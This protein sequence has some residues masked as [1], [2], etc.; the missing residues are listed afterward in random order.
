MTKIM[1]GPNTESKQLLFVTRNAA[2]SLFF[3]YIKYSKTMLNTEFKADKYDAY[4][5]Y[6]KYIELT[7]K[8]GTVV[9]KSGADGSTQ[10]WT[11][12]RLFLEF[13]IND[14][15]KK[16]FL[17]HVTFPL[18]V[19]ALWL[20]TYDFMGYPEVYNVQSSAGLACMATWLL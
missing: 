12:E 10:L 19:S 13:A 3:V 8:E 7:K 6:R 18:P 16:D 17:P 1:Q 9:V 14:E 15:F 11:T 2:A 4:G 20:T 5:R